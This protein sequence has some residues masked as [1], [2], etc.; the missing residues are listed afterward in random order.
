[1]GN[2]KLYIIIIRDFYTVT[3][4][5]GELI[6]ISHVWRI[7]GVSSKMPPLSLSHFSFLQNNYTNY[8]A[9]PRREIQL[10]WRKHEKPYTRKIGSNVF[11][12]HFP[13]FSSILIK[14]LHLGDKW[15]HI[16]RN[17]NKKNLP[18]Y[19]AFKFLTELFLAEK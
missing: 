15:F 5:L 1:M 13:G 16:L 12:L 2:I 8:T 9:K 7:F 14:I 17:L 19:N 18:I 10:L 6:Q 11:P 4:V 3:T